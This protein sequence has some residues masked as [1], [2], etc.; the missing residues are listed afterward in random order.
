[1]FHCGHYP[2]GDIYEQHKNFF[3]VGKDESEAQVK[4]RQRLACE[5]GNYHVDGMIK[6]DIVSGYKI[7]V[8]E[9]DQTSEDFT[10]E[11]I[12]GTLMR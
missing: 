4:L 10:W 12:D 1:M 3:I 7:K 9:L 5:E 6:I 11:L 8:E 2:E